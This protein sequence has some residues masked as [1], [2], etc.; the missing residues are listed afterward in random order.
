MFFGKTKQTKQ[1]ERIPPNQ[2]VTTKFPVLHAGNVP[3]YEDMSKWNLQVYGLVDRP[4]LLSFEDIKAFPEAEVKN[5]I[6][7][8][9][10]WSRLDNI[11]QGIRA[12]DIAGKAGVHKEAG[13]VILHAEEG[14]TANL[15]LSDFTR[16]TSLLAYAH[17]GE[18]LTPEHG[19]PLRG[20]F[21]HLYFWKSAKWLRGIQFTKENHPGF[22]E[23]NGYHMRGDPWKNERFTW[24]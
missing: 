6:H 20:V 2:N 11:W 19:Y 23:K 4:M 13:F 8:V 9:T 22:W 14:W 5:D 16:E 18:P 12:K 1:S 21:P 3:Y 10:G 17:N 15:P 7:C 24:D